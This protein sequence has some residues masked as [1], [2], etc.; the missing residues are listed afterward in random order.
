MAGM[1]AERWA[2]VQT[3]FDDALARAPADRA[4][5]LE[6][7][8][9]GDV[10]LRAE[11]AS[12]VDADTGPTPAILDASSD[13]LAAAVSADVADGEIT[14]RRATA[15]VAG[16]VLGP[17]RLLREIGRG[18]MGTV[19][20]AEREDVGKQVALKLLQDGRATPSAVRRLLAERRVLA[21]LDHPNIAR[22][23]DA[24]VTETGTPFFAME[25]VDGAPLV[26]ACDAQ[27]LGVR[28]RLALFLQ[29]CDAVAYAHRNLV[30]HRDLKPS[31][32]LVRADSTV[33][34]LD[35][36]IAKLLS[37]D[38]TLDTPAPTVGDALRAGDRTSG[39][40]LMTPRY[41]A[42]E[43]RRGGPV[44][45]ATD[46]YAL[47]LLLD[48]L[49]SGRRPPGPTP[50]PM[51]DV[52][53]KPLGAGEATARARTTTPAQL[54]AI[55]A[56]DLDAIVRR[57]T[58]TDPA[59]RYPNAERLAD[60]VRRY[61][62][63]LPV[64]ARPMTFWY[65]TIK[66]VR[67]RRGAATASAG[68]LL[69][70]GV[71]SAGLVRQYEAAR[72]ERDRARLEA[73]TSARVTDFT[74]GLFLGGDPWQGTGAATTAGDLVERASRRVDSLGADPAVQARML[75]VL[76]RVNRTLGHPEVARRQLLRAVA[77]QRAIPGA[78]RLDL[79]SSLADL[80]A[81]YGQGGDFA[82]ADSVLREALAIR[83]S[84]LG[85]TAAPVGTVLAGL[86]T[87]AWMRGDEARAEQ[88]FRQ[89][90]VAEGAPSAAPRAALPI[91]GNLGRMLVN[92][93]RFAEADPILTDALRR[94]RATYGATHPVIAMTLI[95]L[96]HVRAA[97]GDRMV[98]DSLARAA[99]ANV[100]AVHGRQSD[101]YVDALV[102]TAGM[103]FDLGDLRG[104]DSIVTLAIA[105][106]AARHAGERHPPTEALARSADL[107]DDMGDFAR[108]VAPAGEAT[109]IERRSG[110]P[111]SRFYLWYAVTYAAALETAGQTA[112][113]ESTLDAVAPAIARLPATHPGRVKYALWRGAL[114]DATGRSAA[115]EPLFRQVL[116]Y[117]H[118]LLPADDY[119]VG[120]VESR[121]GACLVHLGRASEGR[122]LL[123]H[124]Y[125]TLRARRGD[126]SAMTRA[127]L[128]RLKAARGG[129]P[130][131]SR[132]AAAPGP[133]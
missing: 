16:R 87:V 12:L 114:D 15:S 117:R 27:R 63:G 76:G 80:G 130:V 62:A 104:A 38:D 47:G 107:L 79:A 36:G 28:E 50:A 119:L 67:R 108:A 94:A 49:L 97:R 120:D 57:A 96:A 115:A 85:D 23:L 59:Q 92:Q 133:N 106:H 68:A 53:T 56:G 3:L 18:G 71:A 25:Y 110:G 37:P 122:P 35:F 91:L 10:E 43:Q 24:G 21:R 125:A 39:T 121:L 118:G 89:A 101:A 22:L 111:E 29:V 113:A 13:A 42:P 8:C 128:A 98:A 99:L 4:A 34:L 54:R 14:P 124:G 84:V 78:S 93:G 73:A 66:L 1:T 5:F 52:D 72:R 90:L 103:R 48:E 46:V 33:K 100:E 82:R 70:L 11:V 55:L 19:Y 126:A 2:R 7:A 26:A 132:Q 40:W 31:N 32:V 116:A 75:D 105:M 44:T 20:L 83:R 51:G 60:D 9:G 86:A 112:A 61:V 127:A 6:V 69:L 65:R 109:A 102:E 77:I 74:T 64:R 17:Y 123:E 30:V 95:D 45:T 58:A 131:P 88:L 81:A 129:A 41:A